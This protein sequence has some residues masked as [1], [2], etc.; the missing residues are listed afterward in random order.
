M[1]PYLAG[2]VALVGASLIAVN[3]ITSNIAANIQERAVRLTSTVTDDIGDL[4]TNAATTLAGSLDFNDLA[5][6]ATGPIT[7]WIN[8]FTEAYDNLQVLGGE[9]QADPLPALA[10]VV[11]NQLGFANTVGSD[12]YTIG[13]D[14]YTLLTQT[15]P[16][17]LQTLFSSIAAGDISEGMRTFT[18]SL[19]FDLLP[20]AEPLLGILAVP[21]EVAQNFANVLQQ[22]L[23]DIALGGLLSV[24]SVNYGALQ[25]T[26][27][28]AQLVEN[29][30]NAGQPLQA[31]IDVLNAPAYITGATVNGF[32]SSF[33]NVSYPGILGAYG[34]A[35]QLLVTIPQDIASTLANG[36]TPATWSENLSELIAIITGSLG[37]GV[38]N[39]AEFVPAAATDIG[40]LLATNLAPSL[41][42]LAFSLLSL[43]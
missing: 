23:P 25:S 6:A 12:L 5:S 16:P 2:G 11:S 34:L 18:N 41:S 30:W 32:T 8:V 43:L 22:Q 15:L 26:A 4:T 9:I 21:G 10:Q 20:S 37:G 40:S 13:S 27:D 19:T 3:P 31:L 14:V 33:V 7:S 24:L 28:A 36:A 29:T 17:Q 1:R 39:P 38:L 35:Q 42:G